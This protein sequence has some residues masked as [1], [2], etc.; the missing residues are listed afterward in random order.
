MKEYFYLD[1]NNQQQGPVSPTLFP[2]LGVNR[3]TMVWCAGMDNWVPAGDIP[4]LHDYLIPQ[5][6]STY[7]NSVNNGRFVNNQPYNNGLPQ[8]PPPSNLV[9]G[10][11]TTILCCLPFGI[12]SIVYASQVDSEWNVG[13]Y[14]RAYRKS[15]LA[16]TWAIVAAAAGLIMNGILFFTSLLPIFA[17]LAVG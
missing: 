13:N 14:E 17:G 12:V 8:L 5:P 3:N 4:E 9:W 6:S 1:S 10:I 11:L 2:Q 16:R 7:N 15:N